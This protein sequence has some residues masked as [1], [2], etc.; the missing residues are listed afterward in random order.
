MPFLPSLLTITQKALL[1]LL[2]SIG[3]WHTLK[4]KSESIIPDSILFAHPGHDL[5]EKK[6]SPLSEAMLES[7]EGRPLNASFRMEL[8]TEQNLFWQALKMPL[9]NME[10]GLN[11]DFLQD[12]V[13]GCSHP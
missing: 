7:G 13:R 8:R 4:A 12:K 1:N 11:G 6:S 10:G 2:S 9:W 3:Q 5:F